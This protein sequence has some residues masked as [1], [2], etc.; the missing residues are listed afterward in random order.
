[1]A[2][3]KEIADRAIAAFN[4]HDADALAALD[5]AEVVTTAPGPTGRTEL[6]GRDAS[7]DYNQTWFNAFPDARITIVNQVIS[8][9]TLVQEGRF[10]GT[11]TGAWKTDAGDMPATGKSLN[12]NYC[13]VITFRDGLAI[14]S[15]LYFDQVEVMSQLGLMPVPAG[16]AS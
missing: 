16:A 9:D 6:K 14:S 5:D 11:N 4:A 8:G 15:N 2:D 13:Q 7:R 10:Q 1:M 3:L 12:G